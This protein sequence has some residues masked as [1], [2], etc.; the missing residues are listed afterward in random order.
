MFRRSWNSIIL[1]FLLLFTVCLSQYQGT[2]LPSELTHCNP[3]HKNQCG[4]INK[5]LLDYYLKLWSKNDD[6]YLRTQNHSLAW[7]M[8]KY[9][10]FPKRKLD[11]VKSNQNLPMNLFIKIFR[12]IPEVQKCSLILLYKI[13]VTFVLGINQAIIN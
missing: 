12:Y 6:N 3:S 10:L 11:F 2:L 9:K 5:F 13:T 8:E 7:I 1:C 4:S